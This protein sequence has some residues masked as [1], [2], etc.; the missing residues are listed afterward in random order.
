LKSVRKNWWIVVVTTVL[1]ACGAIGLIVITPPAYASSV[2]F[3]VNTSASTQANPLQSAQYAQQRV[4]TYMGL[5]S[6]ERLAKMVIADTGLDVPVNRVISS[7]SAKSDLNTVLLTAKVTDTSRSRSLEIANSVSTQ[8]VKMVETIDPTVR[9]EVTSGPTLNP[10]PVSP[11]KKLDL[12][13]G[14]LIGLVLGVLAACLREILD[15]TVRSA[16]TLRRVGNA[17]VLAQIGRDPA[18]KKSPLILHRHARST[19]AESFRQLRTNVVFMDVAQPAKVLVVTSATNSEGKTTTVLNLGITFAEAGRRVLVLDGD[20]RR[21]R[22]AEYLGLGGG[23]G[24]TNVLA[25]Q[26]ELTDV[27]QPWAAG[28]L[29]V[30]TSGTVPPNPSELL[31]SQ[32][33]VEL[34]GKLRGM[35]DV[36]LIDT[37]PLLPVTDGAVASAFADGALLVVRYGHAKR[38]Q[39]GSALNSLRSVDARVLGLVFNAAPNKSVDAYLAYEGYGLEDL[40]EAA[41]RLRDTVIRRGATDP[42]DHRRYTAVSN[43]DAGAGAPPESAVSGTA[44]DPR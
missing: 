8:F 11:Q 44:G 24:L 18:A 27:L 6:S 33:M 42:T 28:G 29:T 36:I 22:I 20:L 43:G 38:H 23:A 31:G 19:R 13:V 40:D 14:I 2:T 15:T 10:A 16:E 35:F 7:I 32:P 5:L 30:L 4:T 17:P 25:D 1:G 26:V 3:F 12:G 39:I 41:T 37:P 34:I 9:L 21:P